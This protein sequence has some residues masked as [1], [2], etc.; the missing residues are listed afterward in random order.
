MGAIQQRMIRKLKKVLCLLLLICYASYAYAQYTPV[1]LTLKR[2]SPAV[3]SFDFYVLDVEDSRKIPGARIGN[4]ISLGKDSPLLLPSKAE[5]ELYQYWNGAAPYKND[6]L[7]PVYITIKHLEV[8]EKR[9]ASNGVAGQAK[10]SVS[11]RWYR[12]MQPVELTAFDVGASYTRPETSLVYTQIIPQLLDQALANFN[13]WMKLNT[14]KNPALS[15]NIVLVFKEI[16]NSKN[17]DTVF[18]HPARPL[19]WD[20][21]RAKNFR[22]GSRYAAAVFSS[23]AYEGY[24]Y[25]KGEDMILEIGLKVFMVKDNSWARPESRD[26]S[27]L[28]HEQL[29]FDLTRIVAERFKD[30]LRKADLTIED[31]DSEIQYQFLETFREINEEQ[32]KYDIGTGHGLQAGAQADWDRKISAQIKEIYPSKSQPAF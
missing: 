7:L 4:V 1:L 23:F 15:R 10:L 9:I 29:H 31:H 27:T 3:K 32:Q 6:K 8:S 13:K 18:Y 16:T 22:P 25:T 14:G 19:V 20:D 11:F 26:D 2:E 17:T 21:F 12:N 24:S 30:R 5:K 28:R